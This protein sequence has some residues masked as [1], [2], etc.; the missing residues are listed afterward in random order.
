MDRFIG[1]VL[2]LMVV[3]VL[4][5]FTLAHIGIAI[6]L[7]AAVGLIGRQLRRHST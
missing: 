3:L 5:S 1:A 7:L 4:V 2:Y 6:L